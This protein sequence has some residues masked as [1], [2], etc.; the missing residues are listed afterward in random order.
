MPWVRAGVGLAA[1]EAEEADAGLDVAGAGLAGVGWAG[2]GWGVADGVLG[3]AASVGSMTL[4]T[5]KVEYASWGRAGAGPGTLLVE[6]ADGLKEAGADSRAGAGLTGVGW[7]VADEAL[8]VA[9]SVGS[10]T[11]GT[12]KVEYAS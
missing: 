2:V 7:G 4:G 9:A 10:M 3:V 12:S 6:E 8:G 1:P 11:L 5:S